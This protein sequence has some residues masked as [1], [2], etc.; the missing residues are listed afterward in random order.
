MSEKQFKVDGMSCN[1]CVMAV[2]SA[3]EEI[4]G[5]TSAEVNLEQGTATVQ[6]SGDVADCAIIEAIEEEGFSVAN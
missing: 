6:L 5:V 3:V 1:H 2:K 4:D